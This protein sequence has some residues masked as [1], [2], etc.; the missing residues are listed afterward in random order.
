MDESVCLK[1]VQNVSK[2]SVPGFMHI[3]MDQS[4]NSNVFKLNSEFQESLIILTLLLHR[5]PPNNL[6]LLLSYL[7][8]SMELSPFGEAATP[9]ATPEFSN[10]LWDPKV[11][12]RARKNYSLVSILTQISPVRI[13]LS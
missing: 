12:Y 7:T 4:R 9:S 8:N 3:N 6:V 5:L 2:H 1:Y 11:H 10:V 13:T